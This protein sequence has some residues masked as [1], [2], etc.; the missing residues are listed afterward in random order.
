M[1][2]RH[3]CTV[4]TLTATAFGQ[5][6]D[7]PTVRLQSTR[8]SANFDLLG[9]S[10]IDFQLAGSINPLSWDSNA[11]AD[12]SSPRSRGHFLC[13]D[14]W[15]QPSEAEKKN[16]MPFHGEAAAVAWKLSSNSA[17]ECQ[18]QADLPIAQLRIERTAKLDGATLTVRERITNLGK[19]GRM[20]NVVQ[21]PTIAPPFLDESTVVDANCGKGFAQSAPDVLLNPGFPAFR[22]LTNNPNPNVASFVID[23][24]TGWVTA[25][26]PTH[27][28]AIGYVWSTR[29]YPWLNIWRHVT[30][31][32]PVARGL[33]FGTT[34]LHQPFPEMV[35]RGGRML[36][37]PL[38]AY[39]DAGETQERSYTAFLV[40][41][42]AGA[43]GVRAV[44]ITKDQTEP[45]VQFI[46]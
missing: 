6:P 31:G 38:F 28:L 45:H 9:G 30:D 39:I 44:E 21:H 1:T 25:L 37:R 43:K 34:G 36:D 5:K 46:S 3:A 40:R 8:A 41:T 19:L 22:T 10:L 11:K 18:M 14:R 23:G 33:E 35:R 4:I 42:P 26:A 29:D 16:G 24:P 20:Y 27:N 12:P 13:M 7:R 32:K 17:S 15:G 2:R